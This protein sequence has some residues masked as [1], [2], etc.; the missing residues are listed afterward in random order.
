MSKALEESVAQ[1]EYLS[2]LVKQQ[3]ELVKAASDKLRGDF[4]AFITNKDT[5][6]NVRW[7]FWCNAPIQLKKVEPWVQHF[8]FNDKEISWFDSPVYQDKYTVVKMTNVVDAFKDLIAYGG[9][10]RYYRIETQEDL[11]EALAALKED[12]LAANV[13]SF[14]NDW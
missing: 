4:E 6:L 1:V 11:D 13:H 14:T 10:D 3:E 5:D 8:N 12:I 2:E 7:R 9:E